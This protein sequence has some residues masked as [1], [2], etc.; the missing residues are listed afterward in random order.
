[1]QDLLNRIVHVKRLL[2]A[3]VLIVAS[4]SVAW[5]STLVDHTPALVALRGF[6]WA[7]TAAGL[8]GAALAIL[9]DAQM[10][11]DKDAADDERFRRILRE[12][13]PEMRR[14]VIEG[15]AFEPAELARVATPATLDTIIE[16]SLAIRLEDEQFAR[17]LYQDIRD[18]AV[19]S[20]ERWFETRVSL[21]L[22]PLGIPSGAAKGRPTPTTPMFVVTTTWEYTVVPAHAV[23][24]FTCVSDESAYRD[25]VEDGGN[26][27]AWYFRP[28]GQIDGGDREA[29]ELVRFTVDGEERSIRRSTH[30]RSQTYTVELG[31]AAVERR[32]PVV[33]SYTYRTLTRQHGHLL[34]IDIE[35]PSR[36]LAVELDYTDA[37]IEQ[38]RVLPFFPSSKRPRFMSMP[39]TVPDRTVSV[40]LDG[41]LMPD[42]GVAMVW[43][44][45]NERGRDQ[46]N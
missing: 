24:H 12:E 38:V 11:R 44:L 23:R 28:D 17:E 16:N 36:G 42:S 25:A 39:E 7:E 41:W 9:I 37:P 5:F 33:V 45:A 20:T 10:S 19:Q 46:P 14:A 1:M 43:V 27:S 13:A 26:T 22:S 15:F 2:L 31:E 30:G 32:A 18:Q 4:I 40:A 3:I 21:H 8:F 29:F 6:V 35:Q 34:N